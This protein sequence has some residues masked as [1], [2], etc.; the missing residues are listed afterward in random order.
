[1]TEALRGAFHEF[2]SSSN[3]S[4]WHAFCRRI[5]IDPASGSIAD[6]GANRPAVISSAG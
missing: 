2:A 5:Y 6:A 1:L 3:T 4:P